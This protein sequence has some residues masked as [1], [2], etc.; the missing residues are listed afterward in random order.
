[1]KLKRFIQILMGMIVLTMMSAAIPSRVNANGEEIDP[2]TGP[3][4]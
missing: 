4:D 3:R 2:Q 1:M